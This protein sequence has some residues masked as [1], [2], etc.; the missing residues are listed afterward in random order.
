MYFQF[1]NE[2]IDLHDIISGHFPNLHFQSYP[3]RSLLCIPLFLEHLDACQLIFLIY[4]QMFKSVFSYH[5]GLYISCSDQRKKKP[6]PVFCNLSRK[7]SPRSGTKP[8]FR[9]SYRPPTKLREGIVFTTCNCLCTWPP[10]D[11]YPWCIGPHCPGSPPHRYWHLVAEAYTVGKRL[12]RIL[13][14]YFLVVGKEFIGGVNKN[15]EV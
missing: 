5:S 8:I 6:L 11:H 1:L 13:L 2:F 12:V 4:L 14:E 3:S 7:E 15:S 9:T 10:C